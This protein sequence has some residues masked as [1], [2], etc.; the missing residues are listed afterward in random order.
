LR[1]RRSVP[2]DPDGATRRTAPGVV[3]APQPSGWGCLY[4]AGVVLAV[5][6]VVAGVVLVVANRGGNKR[7]AAPPTTLTV[8][9]GPVPPVTSAPAVSVTSGI[10]V[11]CGTATAPGTLRAVVTVTNQD[12]GTATYVLAIAFNDA[13]GGNMGSKVAVV[14][15]LAAGASRTLN[16]TAIS[17]PNGAQ[18]ANCRVASAHRYVAS[19]QAPSA[20]DGSGG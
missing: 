20:S 5:L 4:A 19:P 3:S 6:L 12:Q 16:V 1:G 18:P 13:A 7:N 17:A 2:E 10:T 15:S 9:G 11:A 8:V 14:P